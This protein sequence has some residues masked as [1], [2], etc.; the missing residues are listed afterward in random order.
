MST[1]ITSHTLNI[2]SLIYANY[3]ANMTFIISSQIKL[4]KIRKKI[5]QYVKAKIYVQN[6]HKIR[7]PND[8]YHVREYSIL[9]LI[10][11]H[12]YPRT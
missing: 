12:M 9:F 2:C 3:I 5:I 4:L 6:L 10:I 8:Q 1:L 7:Y 11:M